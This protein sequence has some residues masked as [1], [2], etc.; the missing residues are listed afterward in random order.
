MKTK[1]KTIALVEIA[2]V[3]CSVFFLAIPAITADQTAQKASA[4]TVTTASEDDYVLEIYGNANEDDT[5][6]M[7]DLTYVKLIFFGKKPETE[8]ADAKYDGKINPLDFIQIKLIIVG[9]EKE[10]TVV[11]DTVTDTYPNGKPVTVNK[12]IKRIILLNS[13]VAEAIKVLNA[14][15]KVVGVT[16]GITSRSTFFPEL[17]KLPC[18]GKW[19]ELDM[20]RMLSLNPDLVVGYGGSS[21]S[22][23][24]EEIFKDLPITVVK[25]QFYVPEI[26]TE[27]IEKL[28]YI[29]GKVEAAE[30]YI[31]FEDEC[32]GTINER[33]GRLSEAEKPRVYLEW[34]TKAYGTYTK[35]SGTHQICTIAGGIN[36]AADLSGPYAK[37]DPEWVITQ[38]PD[39]VFKHQ[40][41]G[42]GYEVDNPSEMKARWDEV[43]NRPELANV[44]AV[45]EER[46]YLI[47]SD[48]LYGPAYFVGIACMAKWF[49]PDMFADFNPQAIHQEYVD[50]FCDIDFDVTEHG[51]FVYPEPS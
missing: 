10:I 41:A 43:M 21:Y 20:E 35:G 5:I 47:S 1:N 39:I 51:V 12:P 28:A 38:N 7:R 2:I 13:D 25:L 19:K 45:K 14:R 23:K 16:S 27:D 33:V 26:M 17:S 15:D 46:V 32:M 44:I 4:S 24:M 18:V 50:K 40:Y 3:L 9:K 36:I 48:I 34:A 30:E 37:V 8:L 6:D 42:S 31:G 11:D 49:H 29:L 22:N